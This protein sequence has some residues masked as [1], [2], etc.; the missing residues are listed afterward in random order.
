MNIIVLGNK[1]K[2][3]ILFELSFD[4]LESIESIMQLDSIKPVVACYSL[5]SDIHY[6][7]LDPIDRFLALIILFCNFLK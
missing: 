2:D 5:S 4:S 3:Y 6:S 7:I 1:S